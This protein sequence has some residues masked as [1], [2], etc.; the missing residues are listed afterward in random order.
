[1]IA[2]LSTY[3]N[4]IKTSLR[5]SSSVFLLDFKKLKKLEQIQN[6][7]ENSNPK[8]KNFYTNIFNLSHDL[9]PTLPLKKKRIIK[10]GGRVE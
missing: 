4:S 5:G 8:I 1:M 10:N 3:R 9:K 7:N 2:P 6:L